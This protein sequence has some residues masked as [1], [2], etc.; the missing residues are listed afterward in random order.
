MVITL[1]PQPTKFSLHLT[2]QFSN[3]H[4][5]IRLLLTQTIPPINF[6]FNFTKKNL[7][8]FMFRQLHPSQ[9]IRPK[10]INVYLSSHN[11]FRP[12][13]SRFKLQRWESII[14]CCARI[15]PTLTE[16]WFLAELMFRTNNLRPIVNLV[17]NIKHDRNQQQRSWQV[18]SSNI[19]GFISQPYGSLLTRSRKMERYHLRTQ[20]C[21]IVRKLQ[22][23]RS[24]P[25][26]V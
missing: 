9:L 16:Q 21:F 24:F 12:N 10:N 19:W 1:Y 18:L 25:Y 4:F 23:P 26:T 14:I 7:Y 5:R 3:I 22:N 8:A 15:F 13:V 20:S 17:V 11:Y 2:T 6:L